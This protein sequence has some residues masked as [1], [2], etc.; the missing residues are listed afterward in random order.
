EGAGGALGDAGGS[1][2]E[3][4]EMD[5]VELQCVEIGDQVR[6]AEAAVE[7]LARVPR[8]LELEDVGAGT[9]SQRVAAA[10]AG[11][12][13]VAAAPALYDVGMVGADDGDADGH[14]RGV[15]RR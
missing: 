1:D 8:A 11:L 6:I 2:A 4:V 9:T 14:R 12:E 7:P 3:A 13:R 15:H 10:A 5:G